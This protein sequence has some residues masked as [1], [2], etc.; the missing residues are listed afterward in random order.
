MSQ[1]L[2]FCDKTRKNSKH[3]R[4]LFPIGGN[5]SKIP[6][7]VTTHDSHEIMAQDWTTTR[8]GLASAAGSA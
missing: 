4:L 1:T 7:G 2:S 5:P 6:G 3:S 8:K